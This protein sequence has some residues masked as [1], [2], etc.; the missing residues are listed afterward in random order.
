[1]TPGRSSAA[2]AGVLA[3][4]LLVAIG[5]PLP[6]LAAQ[7]APVPRVDLVSADGHVSTV[8]VEVAD[9]P[10]LWERGLMFRSEMAEDAGMVFVFPNDVTFG[11]WMQN[12]PL[13]LSIAWIAADGR[14]VDIQDMQPQSTDVHSPPAPYRFALEVNQGYFARH[15]VQTGDRMLALWETRARLLLIDR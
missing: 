11:F 2:K 5:W 4:A 13:P 3:V 12:T 14:I 10:G 6:S 15:G 9:E 1:L 7:P 8:R